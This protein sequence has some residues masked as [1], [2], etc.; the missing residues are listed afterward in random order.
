MGPLCMA[1]CP[2]SALATRTARSQRPW[3]LA[4]GTLK[5]TR[6]PSLVLK[7]PV[8]KVLYGPLALL[9]YPIAVCN[10]TVA[11]RCSSAHIPSEHARDVYIHRELPVSQAQQ[12]DASHALGPQPIDGAQVPCVGGGKETEDGGRV[13]GRGGVKWRR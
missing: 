3:S 8:Q 13:R 1:V 12:G 11:V 5:S 2:W 9:T 6:L 10:S 7:G 4:H